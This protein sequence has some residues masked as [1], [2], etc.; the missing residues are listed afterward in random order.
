M[1]KK[2]GLKIFIF[3]FLTAVIILL[4]ASVAQSRTLRRS[5]PVKS[6]VSQ[7]TFYK[8]VKYKNLTIIP[9]N[10]PDK[11]IKGGILTL[12]EAISAGTLTV[13]EVSR[14]GSVNSLAVTNNSRKPVYIMAGEILRG[15][16]QDRVLKDDALIPPKS[17][18]IIVSAFCVEKGRWTYKTDKFKSDKQT[19]NISV[20][21]MAKASK[22]QSAVWDGVAETN[23]RFNAKESGSLAMSYNSKE[24]KKEKSRYNSK[25]INIPK[26]YPKANGVVVIIN[27]E[28]L[29]ADVF[30][31]RVIFNKL[32]SK[33]AD[34]YTLEAISRSKMPYPAISTSYE[35]LAKE[36]FTRIKQ[37]DITY[38]KSPGTGKQ[39]E[40]SSLKI[41]GSGLL[42]AG[43]PLH[44][45]AFP[46]PPVKK[47][48]K[49]IPQLQRNYSPNQQQQN[50]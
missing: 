21:Q 17:G 36:F 10:A 30:S 34:S 11:S 44:L 41:T 7:C 42:Y 32:W 18:K 37:A 39:I 35:K 25:I 9:V 31:D 20:R 28:V 48:P 13:T 38:S 29:V 1:N 45:D 43:S 8:P 14:S 24:V 27:G 19:A 49:P 22:S 2:S 33:L 47:Q 5:D 16:K 46:R 15:S 12:D 50:R 3:L 23:K 26:K 6:F 40:I 4:W